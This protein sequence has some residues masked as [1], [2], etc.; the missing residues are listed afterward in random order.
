MMHDRYNDN[1]QIHTT[2][3]A[4]MDIVHVGKSVLPTPTRLLHLNN[5]LHVPHAHKHLVSI[6]C[7][8]LG[9]HTFIELH[10]FFFLIK[11]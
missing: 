2:N 4:G 9:N 3:G 8:N 5:V 7:F 11:D 1:N 10:P 6:H